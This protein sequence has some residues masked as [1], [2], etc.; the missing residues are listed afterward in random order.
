MTAS[1]LFFADLA[2]LRKIFRWWLP[3]KRRHP[4]L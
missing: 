4:S 2:S 3:Q 1:G